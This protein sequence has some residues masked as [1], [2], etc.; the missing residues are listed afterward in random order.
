MKRRIA[1]GFI[2]NLLSIVVSGDDYIIGEAY[3]QDLR[4]TKIAFISWRDRASDIYV[5]NSDGSNPRKLTDNH[6][7][8]YISW[9]PDGAKIAFTSD[10]SGNFEIYVMNSDGSNLTRLTNNSADDWYSSWSPDGRKIAFTS[11]RDD[12]YEIY[13]MN[14]DGSNQT[15]LTNNPAGDALPSWSPDGRK[16]AFM[17]YRDGNFEIYVMNSDG[18]NQTRL[19]NDPANDD[20]PSWSPDG[21]KIA[22][23]S[24]RDG[25][26]EIYAMNSDGSNP[27]RLTNNPAYD[28]LPSWSPDGR[29]ITFV[30]SRD[31]NDEIYVMNSDG[32]NQLNLTNNPAD[33][34]SPSWSPFLTTTPPPPLNNPPELSPIDNKT[35][36][37]GNT[38]EFR[39]SATDKDGNPITYSASNLPRGATFDPSTRVFSWTPGFDQAGSYDV[40]FRVSDGKDTVSLIVKIQVN[41]ILQNNPPIASFTISPLSG[42]TSATFSVDASFSSDDKDPTS[43]LQVHWDWENDGV[44]DTDWSTTKTA[45]HIYSSSG[46]KT[47][48][49][50]VKDSSGLTAATTK[51][52]TVTQSNN[53]PEF[54]SIGAQSIDE[55]K[56]L[57]FTISASDKDGD[58]LTYSVVN[59]PRGATFDPTTKIFSWKPGSDQA[60]SYEVTFRV[61]DGKDTV[62]QVIRVQVND[63]TPQLPD[64]SIT[65]IRIDPN[66]NLTTD[67]LIIEV[68]VKNLQNAKDHKIVFYS[69][70][71]DKLLPIIVSKSEGEKILA[72]LKAPPKIIGIKARI[73]EIN[74]VPVNIESSKAI[75]LFYVIGNN[76]EPYDVRKHG[77]SFPNPF[78]DIKSLLKENLPLSSVIRISLWDGM[79]LGMA[80]SSNVYFQDWDAKP[81]GLKSINT[82]EM[83]KENPDV[84][85]NVSKYHLA[86]STSEPSLRA[87]F[88]NTFGFGISDM[89]QLLND[90][91][92]NITEKNKPI[93]LFMMTEDNIRHAVSIFKIIENITEGIAYL[94]MYDNNYNGEVFNSAKI[95]YR[96]NKFEY[97]SKKGFKYTKAEAIV[98]EKVEGVIERAANLAKITFEDQNKRKLNSFSIGSPA[99]MLVTDTNGH[100]IGFVDGVTKVS[101]IPNSEILEVE[102]EDG[103]KAYS[104]YVPNDQNYTAKYFGKETGTMEIETVMTQSSGDPI[105]LN[106]NEV[107]ITPQTVASLDIN[108]ASDFGLKTDQNGDGTIDRAF[109]PINMLEPPGGFSGE[110]SMDLNIDV[111]QQNQ[112]QISV[113]PEDF[114]PVEI[115]ADSGANG[116]LGFQVTLNYDPTILRVGRVQPLPRGGLIDDALFFHSSPS[117][118]ILKMNVALTGTRVE[119]NAGSLGLVLFEIIEGFE[120]ETKV[121]LTSGVFATDGGQ[122]RIR[123]NPEKATVTIAIQTAKTPDFN[124]DGAVN[125]PDFLQF[126]QNFGKKKGDSA[127]EPKYDLNNNEA[128]DFPDFI[129]FAQ[130]FGKKV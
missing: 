108:G 70:S 1:L 39:V 104:Y 85:K 40:T 49:L 74:G 15:R 23:A 53:P 97:I 46:T 92:S 75:N 21:R 16:I 127:F 96:N 41:D 122:K 89:K 72:V 34:E 121:V 124:G 90:I 44:W 110:I 91:K 77:Y 111:G 11:N 62:S 99:V 116:I 25:N 10:M 59:P 130:E 126:A 83:M 26:Y 9:S 51:S 128:V 94:Y 60:G 84:I 102:E 105:V 5:M 14:S 101:E 50:E 4:D 71:P 64:L 29:K 69:D 114:V 28:W 13:V 81:Q 107:P 106:Y 12:D 19:T 88:P 30:S 119:A 27:T 54:S 48:K 118:G 45:S 82:F 120:G 109:A 58:A 93:L 78:R 7:N 80:A 57:T 37:E 2:I 18:S 42:T 65:D 36:E 55:G 35:V 31:G 6:Y 103:S 22:F 117:P 129:K 68:F 66:I 87:I 17:S 86:Y 32:S 56:T 38:L 63:V 43:Q 52:V 98:A 95:D 123:V 112:Y 47:V 20:Y 125:F 33:D 115:I 76:G 73:I 113:K 79:C 100:R 3:G 8:T 61:S 67:Q 24:N